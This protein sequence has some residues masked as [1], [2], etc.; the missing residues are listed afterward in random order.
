MA[1]HGPVVHENVDRGIYGP[2]VPLEPPLGWIEYASNGEQRN[3]CVFGHRALL[4]CLSQARF[5]CQGQ[6]RQ[7]LGYCP[8]LQ[9]HGLL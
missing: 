6:S 3:M 1:V 8:N 2:A 7:S 9:P 5:R 4:A